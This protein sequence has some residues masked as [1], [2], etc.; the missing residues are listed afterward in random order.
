MVT[1]ISFLLGPAS[2]V[3]WCGMSCI[4][5]HALWRPRAGLDAADARLAAA[6]SMSDQVASWSDMG[7]R[8]TEARLMAAIHEVDDAL[9]LS[10]PPPQQA[11]AR[12]PTNPSSPP[13]GHTGLFIL[14]SCCPITDLYLWG[15]WKYSGADA[16]IRTLRVRTCPTCKRSN[17]GET[18]AEKVVY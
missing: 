6:V 14:V 12:Q 2:P 10:E 5:S 8:S 16:M 4:L 18:V 13:G 7:A 9:T 11:A 1:D 3:G 15:F 17:L